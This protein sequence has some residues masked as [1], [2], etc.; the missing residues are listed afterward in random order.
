[1][2]GASLATSPT[3]TV[4]RAHRSVSACSPCLNLKGIGPD[5]AGRKDRFPR[6]N[7][8]FKPA[9]L[10]KRGGV[11]EGG[12]LSLPSSEVGI[13]Q[14]LAKPPTAR[15]TPH[16]GTRRQSSANVQRRPAQAGAENI[17][18]RVRLPASDTTA[19]PGAVP[20]TACGAVWRWSASGLRGTS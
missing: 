9:N 13:N 14:S 3:R 7:A 19:P 20:L 17:R 15:A 12:D 16:L 5:H 11:A 1:M 18:Q 8:L 6:R 10:I 4:S 2:G